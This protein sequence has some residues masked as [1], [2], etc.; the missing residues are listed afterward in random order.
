MTA[1]ADLRDAVTA[2]N[3]TPGRLP[4]ALVTPTLARCRTGEFAAYARPVGADHDWEWWVEASTRVIGNNHAPTALGALTDAGELI[5]L[6]TVNQ[7]APR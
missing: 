1:P 5:R 6:L 2:T 3:A 7:R 4:W